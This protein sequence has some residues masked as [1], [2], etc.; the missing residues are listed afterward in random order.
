MPTTEKTPAPAAP[1]RDRVRRLRRRLT[2][3]DHATLGVL[4]LLFGSA[5]GLWGATDAM[6]LRTGLLTPT[7][8][9]WTA[10]TYNGL[11]TT[12]GLTMLFFFATPV[13]FGISIYFLPPLMGAD[14]VSSP[15]LTAVA[16]WLL[17]PALLLSRAGL[18][19]NLIGIEALAPPMTG[20]T[21]YT[22]LSASM[23]N[24]DLN[25]VLMGI[26]LNGISTI[27]TAFNLLA[28]IVTERA[29]SIG[30]AD[31]DVFTWSILTTC[32]MI[33]VAFPVLCSAVL[34]LLSDRNA[35]TSF[36]L[37]GGG[38][39][40]PLLWQNLF[41][42]FGHPEVYILVLPSMGLLSLILPRFA[43]RELFGHRSVVYSTVAI[44]LL[45]LGVW[46]HHMFATGMDPRTHASFMAVTLA[47]ALPSAAK[48][49][50]WLMTLWAGEIRLTV[51][52]L[53]CLAAVG[54]FV[55]GGVTGVFLA[56]IP[57]DLIYQGTYYV[58][59]HFHLLLVGTI[60]FALFGA[61]YYWFPILTGR[62]YDRTLA[63]VHFWL[64]VSGAGLAF[65]LFLLM[66]IWGLPRRIATYPDPFTPLNQLATVGAYLLGIG[67]LVW[68]W[69][70]GHSI[71]FG[72]EVECSDVWDLSE[73]GMLSREWEWFRARSGGDND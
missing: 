8:D 29:E 31:L 26:F 35:G 27:L 58:V 73:R 18:L 49:F 14:D 61:N 69:N 21:F 59:G 72:S 28:T 11:F 6:L 66:G 67:Q 24:P 19:A 37:A 57:V 71:R 43:G 50:D 15:R 47:I 42:F 23:S 60:V 32:G 52:M 41:W 55:V 4:Y 39:G 34:M 16:F 36:F 40:G 2:A 53:F 62:M 54:N 22:P 51:P 9:I 3:T 20:W 5:A 65:H 44:G 70:M 48:T 45:S 12:H 25:L 63:K 17:P 33:L 46:G 30:W 64:S 1:W 68:L 38:S 10:A 13:V 56:A 7:A